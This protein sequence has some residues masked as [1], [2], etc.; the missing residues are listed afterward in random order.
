MNEGYRKDYLNSKHWKKQFRR[1]WMKRYGAWCRGCFFNG[2]LDLHHYT[3]DRVGREL[4]S[5]VVTLCRQCHDVAHRFWES[6]RHQSRYGATAAA[7][8]WRREHP[9]QRGLLASL[10][11]WL[12]S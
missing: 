6:G 10:W 12:H 1:R 4:D 3:Y 7:I 9:P 5:D 2:R 11:R 8:A